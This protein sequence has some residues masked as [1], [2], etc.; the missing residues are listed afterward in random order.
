MTVLS[1]PHT[2]TS[3]EMAKAEDSKLTITE[4]RP[5]VLGATVT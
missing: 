3:S 2:A 1:L 5:C 4:S